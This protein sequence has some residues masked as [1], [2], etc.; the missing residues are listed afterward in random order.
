MRDALQLRQSLIP[1]IYSATREAFETGL[2]LLRPMY[3]YNPKVDQAYNVPEQY[4]FG[5]KMLIRPI[6][7]KG[8]SSTMAKIT[9]WLPQVSLY[10]FS[11]FFILLT[12]A[13]EL[14]WKLKQS[15]K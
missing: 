2:A 6:V 12:G 13:Y 15:S 10:H 3:Y 1:Y 9:V 11:W 7:E 4:Y 5:S 14:L 8:D